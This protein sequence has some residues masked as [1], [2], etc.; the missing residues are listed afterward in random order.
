MNK[1]ILLLLLTLFIPFVVYAETCNNDKISITSITMENITGSASELDTSIINDKS[2]NVN[3]GLYNVGDS[4]RYKMVIK[5]DSN[6]DYELDQTS[7]VLNTD[8]VNYSFEPVGDSKLIKAGSSKE[9]YLL[10]SYNNKVPA[11]Q[12]A[13]GDFHDNNT[14]KVNL[15]T[16]ISNP[17]T[18]V[19]NH[20]LALTL[21]LILSMGA[22]LLLRKKGYAT[23]FITIAGIAIIIP[24]TVNAICKC[25]LSIESNVVI[26]DKVPP[27]LFEYYI[28]D[29]GEI[30]ITDYYVGVAA[31]DIDYTISDKT[32]CINYLSELYLND[33][34]DYNRYIY[35]DEIEANAES[36]CSGGRDKHQKTIGN[37]IYSNIPSQDYENAGLSNVSIT[38]KT[39]TNGTDVVIPDY[40]D[41]Y[42]VTIIGI[43]SFNSKGL[44]SVKLP[45]NL[46]KIDGADE[47]GAFMSNHLTSIEFP[48]SLEE[49]RTYAFA[50]NELTEVIIPNNVTYI[51][52]DAFDFNNISS[53]VLGEKVESIEYEAFAANNLT[54][55][56]IPDSVKR[57]SP[58]LHGVSNFAGA[59]AANPLTSVTIEGKSS[60]S[61]F[62]H[63]SIDYDTPFSWDPNVTCVKDND[64]NV[65]NG[66]ITWLGTGEH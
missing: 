13:T 24:I 45:S 21:V 26:S 57:L 54:T 39:D 22:Y 40:I 34:I 9:V 29:D 28:N 61:D 36:L 66:C 64:G 1:K 31:S 58:C 41:G 17:K 37:L 51:G 52:A 46:R 7:L 3:L 65:E 18:G 35:D 49:I 53:L 30:E 15:S 11:E 16:G 59:F 14:L 48:E 8:Y 63:Y 25:E 10:V 19:E 6:E 42:P 4:I 2:I 44:T 47:N 12:F 50:N 27:T 62:I 60:F 55:V 33:Y 5:N 56:T 38:P 20:I 32:K 43:Y 23:L